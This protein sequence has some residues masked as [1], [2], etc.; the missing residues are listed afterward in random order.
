MGRM[1]RNAQKCGWLAGFEPDFVPESGKK[2]DFS[3]GS[4]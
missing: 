1:A 2:A 3:D 4:R